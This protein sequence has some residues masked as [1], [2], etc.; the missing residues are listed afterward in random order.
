M[1]EVLA[2][3]RVAPQSDEAVVAM[4]VEIERLLGWAEGL[5]VHDAESVKRATDDLV[6]LANL[7]R[8]IEDKRKEY[9][10]PVN[11]HLKAINESFRGMT[12]PLDNADRITREKVLAYR[13]EEQRKAREAERINELRLEAARRE[14]ELKGELTEPVALVEAPAPQPSRVRTDVGTLGTTKTRKWEVEDLSR[15]PLEY[16]MVDASRVGRVVRAGVPSIPGIRI[17]EDESLRVTPSK[18]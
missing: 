5:Q 8:A 1:T 4:G 13:Q 14:M 9:T 18:S 12:V 7:K 3:V 2:T 17:W 11:D 16:L 10:G 15:V 6:L